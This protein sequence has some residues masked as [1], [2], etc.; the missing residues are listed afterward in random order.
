MYQAKK[1]KFLAKLSKFE[2]LNIK[3]EE[4]P[5]KAEVS[6]KAKMFETG[7]YNFGNKSGSWEYSL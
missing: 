3:P 5:S 7:M 6:K 1:A 2:N 4:K